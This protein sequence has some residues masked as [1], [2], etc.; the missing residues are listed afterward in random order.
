MIKTGENHAPSKHF[1]SSKPSWRLN[2]VFKTSWKT[3]KCYTEDVFIK[4]SV[5]WAAIPMY[6]NNSSYNSNIRK[7]LAYREQLNFQNGDTIK[8]A[9]KL[10]A[11]VTNVLTT[12]HQLKSK[13][14]YWV[15][16]SLNPPPTMLQLW[17]EMFIQSR[18]WLLLKPRP[19]PWTRTLQNLDPEKPELRKT[20]TL[21][22]LDPE[23]PGLRNTWI[24]KN[25]DPEKSGLRKFWTMKN[26][27]N[28]WMQKQRLED[29]MV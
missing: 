4:T 2:Y 27:E 23:K 13:R 1:L 17:N 18:R 25:L 6:Y 21:K 12:F 28:N 9:L 29:H 15:I 5:C 10:E 16:V 22:N 8:V 26:A 24:L 11:S 20:W 14:G 19:R 3:K 7:Y